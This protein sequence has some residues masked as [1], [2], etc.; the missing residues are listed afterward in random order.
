MVYTETT[1]AL[2]KKLEPT[3]SSQNLFKKVYLN[4]KW[5]QNQK[6]TEIYCF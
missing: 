3:F 4:Q 1:F 6:S 5:K 2:K